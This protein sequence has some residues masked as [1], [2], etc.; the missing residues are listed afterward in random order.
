MANLSFVNGS[1]LRSY[2]LVILTDASFHNS[3]IL[4]K[5]QWVPW[6]TLL[7]SDFDFED[8]WKVRY[9]MFTLKWKRFENKTTIDEM[10]NVIQQLKNDVEQIKVNLKSLHV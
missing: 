4:L 8:D 2:T 7:A 3:T 5:A 10:V 6:T 9:F 1:I